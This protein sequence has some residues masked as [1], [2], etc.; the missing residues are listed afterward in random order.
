MLARTWRKGSPYV[1]LVRVCV[2]VF[3]AQ[4]HPTLCNPTD[5]N[6]QGSFV[7]GI[8][9]K[10]TGVGCHSLLQGILLTQESKPSLPHS[11][12]ILYHP[13]ATRE[14]PC[15][16]RECQLVQILR[17]TVWRFLKKLKLELSYNPTVPLVFTQRK[18]NHY[19]ENISALQC[20]K[21]HFLQL[22]SHGN[23]RSLREFFF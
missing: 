2:C 23:K 8:P 13:R 21:K 6:P 14:A 15:C 5:C 10:K 20:S 11:C 22:A 19:F 7:H 4:S 18:Q 1:L 12:R 16:W 17:K 9:G 3:V